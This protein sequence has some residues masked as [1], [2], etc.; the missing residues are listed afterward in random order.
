MNKLSVTIAYPSDANV[1]AEISKRAFLSDVVCG[2]KGEGGPPGYESA[3]WQ[4]FMMKKSKYHKFTVGDVTIGGA[5]VI[6]KSKGHY[7]LGRIF[8]DPKY[9]RKGIGTEAMQLLLGNYPDARRWTLETPPWNIRTKAF[10]EKLGFRI[11]GESSQDLFF[12]KIMT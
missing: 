5:I 2:G 10:Y 12:E 6:N 8:I 7:Y 3:Q 11:I 9:H 4:V 1:L